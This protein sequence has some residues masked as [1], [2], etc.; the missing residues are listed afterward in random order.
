MVQGKSFFIMILKDPAIV[1]LVTPTPIASLFYTSGWLWSATSG[2]QVEIYTSGLNYGS[3][4]P[5]QI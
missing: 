3:V 1:G 4:L 5:N 2:A